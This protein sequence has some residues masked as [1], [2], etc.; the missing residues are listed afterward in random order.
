[1]SGRVNAFY[2]KYTQ[3]AVDN[4]Y[5]AKNF[6]KEIEKKQDLEFCLSNYDNVEN[7]TIVTCVFSVMA[8]ES[9]FNDFAA[10]H[11]GDDEFYDNFDRLSLLSKFQLIAKFILKVDV[12]KSRSYYSNL[13]TTDS[14]RNEFVHN[15][16]KDFFEW[17]KK[18]KSEPDYKNEEEANQENAIIRVYIKS[19]KEA[20]RNAKHAIEAIRDIA[21]FFDE[22]DNTCWATHHLFME[23]F[24]FGE[25]NDN[26]HTQELK[27]EFKL[28]IK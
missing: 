20:L 19:L 13:K 17:V 9:Y 3:I 21:K 10:K 1:M 23:Y 11:L 4:Y 5:I 16:S 14:I 24:S 12:D 27:R 22:A 8:L 28:G 7:A 25:F 18:D 2:S 26:I 15:K 6:L